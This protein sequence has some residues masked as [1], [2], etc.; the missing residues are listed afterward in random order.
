MLTVPLRL[1]LKIRHTIH[2]KLPQL[3]TEL[4]HLIRLTS[5]KGSRILR[6]GEKYIREEALTQ[7]TNKT[8]DMTR[9]FWKTC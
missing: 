7:Q 1:K 2:P 3:T 9:N 5:L 8:S 4:K 6:Q